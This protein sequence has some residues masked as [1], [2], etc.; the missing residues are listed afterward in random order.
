MLLANHGVLVFGP[1][2]RE[3]AAL[4][5]VLEEAAE[6]ELAACALG[7]AVSFP[8]GALEDVR[9]SMARARS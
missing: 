2:P 1:G 3:A 4:L 7:G 8:P 5:T 6:A 9:A